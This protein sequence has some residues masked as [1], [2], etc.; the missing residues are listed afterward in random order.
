MAW[1]GCLGVLGSGGVGE[2]RVSPIVDAI[3]II[4]GTRPQYR[5]CQQSWRFLISSRL[6]NFIQLLKFPAFQ[7]ATRLLPH[8][9]PPSRM[10]LPSLAGNLFRQRWHHKNFQFHLRCTKTCAASSKEQG[11]GSGEAMAQAMRGKHSWR[12]GA[13]VVSTFQRHESQ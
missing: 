2:W 7:Q 1:H 8:V 9:H 10:N 12:T 4:L 5:K 6:T 3:K 11:E 13:S